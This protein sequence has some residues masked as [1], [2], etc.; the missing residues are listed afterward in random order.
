MP[1]FDPRARYPQGNVRMS[2]PT[3]SGGVGRQAP[4][5]RAVNE[6]QDIDNALVTLERSVEKRSPLQFIRR[7][8]NNSFATLDSD[9]FSR[10]RR[11][12]Y[13]DRC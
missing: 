6:A 10:P 9:D 1:S 7:Y 8:T 2:I 13:I 5:K 4:T 11:R 3:L 12:D